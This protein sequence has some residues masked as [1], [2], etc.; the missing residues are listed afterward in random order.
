MP[1]TQLHL[2]IDSNLHELAKNSNLNLSAEFEEWVRVRLVRHTEIETENIDYG[3]E[4]AKLIQEL[5]LLESKE[6]L[7]LKQ[8]SKEKEEKMI[9]DNIIENMKEF[10]QFS[11]EDIK[12][13]ARGLVFLFKK[14][15]NKIITLEQANKIIVE[16][17]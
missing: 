5:A 17:L 9:I 15:L 11:D 14:K 6:E 4:K 10:K 3:L 12:T 1:K 8:E 13:R 16:R 7:A 2:S